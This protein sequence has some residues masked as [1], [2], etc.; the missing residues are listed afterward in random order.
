MKYAA[1]FALLACAGFAQNFQDFVVDH[2]QRQDSDA[3]VSFLLDGPAGKH[4]FIRESG[5]HLAHD[6]GRFRIWG[7]NIVGFVKGSALLP[8]KDQSPI[9]AA[10]FARL[11]I[12]CVRFHF[13]D[14]TT[15]E[16]P[17]GLIDGARTDS[18]VFDKDQID[19]LDY[20]IYQL[21][22]RGIYSDLNLNVGRDYK[23]GD[24]VPDSNLIGV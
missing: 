4:G 13:L 17:K 7:V 8:P 20:F 9:W 18:R 12:N 16:T 14:R 15:S 2:F 21:K 24:D 19:R 10:E 3:D 5:G 11:G 23:P 22:Q 1:L 6:G